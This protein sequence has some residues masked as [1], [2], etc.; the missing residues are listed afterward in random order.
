MSGR[1]RTWLSCV[2]VI[3]R[4]F[5]DLRASYIRPDD[6]QKDPL[7]IP[8]TDGNAC[9]SSPLPTGP[10]FGSPRSRFPPRWKG[11]S[12]DCSEVPDDCPFPCLA[13]CCNQLSGVF[14][15]CNLCP[16][17]IFIKEDLT[18]KRKQLSLG[19]KGPSRSTMRS[20]SEK[21]SGV[22]PKPSS[23]KGHIKEIQ[24]ILEK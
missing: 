9:V 18:R 3:N 20:E 2:S 22:G 1:G 4:M 14:E 10:S 8:T 21:E 11:V 7:L 13:C 23:I 15:L 12:N 5:N 19:S 17:E 24:I 6:D 16:G